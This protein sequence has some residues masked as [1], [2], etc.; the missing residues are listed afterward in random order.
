MRTERTY[1]QQLQVLQHNF[2]DSLQEQSEVDFQKLSSQ[3]QIMCNYSQSLLAKLESQIHSW[4]AHSQIGRV[5]LDYAGFLKVYTQY[6]QTYR[7]IQQAISQA[8][9]KSSRFAK[10]LQ[11]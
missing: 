7:E 8:R 10:R 5:F 6:V 1:Y 9:K 3:I 2:L 4:N 11:V